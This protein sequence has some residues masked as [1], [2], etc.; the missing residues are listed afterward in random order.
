[1]VSELQ[2]RSTGI[3]Y[4]AQST[5]RNEACANSEEAG[6]IRKIWG[7]ETGGLRRAHLMGEA[8]LGRFNSRGPARGATGDLLVPAHLQQLCCDSSSAPIRSSLPAYL[9]DQSPQRPI[10]AKDLRFRLLAAHCTGCTDVRPKWR[11]EIHFGSLGAKH[12]CNRASAFRNLPSV[13][14]GGGCGVCSRGGERCGEGLNSVY[15]TG[16]A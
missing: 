7:L 5:F 12:R 11:L 1:M 16:I 9:L 8:L 3:H 13:A 14:H 6:R 15:N 2:A 4:V 10:G